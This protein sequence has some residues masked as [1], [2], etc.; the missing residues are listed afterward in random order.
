MGS[1]D[2]HIFLACC[3]LA[4]FLVGLAGYGVAQGS[5]WH[6]FCGVLDLAGLCVL[7]WR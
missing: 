7:S 1:R 4:P 6:G 2:T 5:V 3:G